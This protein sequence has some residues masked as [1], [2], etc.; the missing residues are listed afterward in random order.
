MVRAL[1][2]VR[3]TRPVP[4]PVVLMEDPFLLVGH[5]AHLLVKPSVKQSK[6]KRNETQLAEE[7]ACSQV[8]YTHNGSGSFSLC[9]FN[10]FRVSRCFSSRRCFSAAAPST[11]TDMDGTVRPESTSISVQVAR[12]V[13]V[14]RSPSSSFRMSGLKRESVIG[15]VLSISVS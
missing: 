9:F 7:V 3:T 5:L 11:T 4:I 15:N 10:S 13:Y 1:E 14:P 8:K 2:D 12:C 6:Q